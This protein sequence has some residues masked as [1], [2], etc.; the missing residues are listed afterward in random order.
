MPALSSTTTE[1][2]STPLY[3]RAA[4]AHETLRRNVESCARNMAGTVVGDLCRVSSELLI[5]DKD[6]GVSP[7]LVHEAR[8][9]DHEA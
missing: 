8:H 2:Q 9:M 7:D 6:V 4:L 3:V 5:Q 1:D